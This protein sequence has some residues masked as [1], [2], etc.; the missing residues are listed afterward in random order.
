MTPTDPRIDAYIA[1]SA[2]FAKPIL[3][4]LR[5]VV[6]SSC[7]DAQETIKWGMPHFMY[8]DRILAQMAAFKAHCAFSF[9]RNLSGTDKAAE[10]MGQFGRITT[11]DDL[12]A[13]AEL[14][15]L[16]KQAAAQIDAGGPPPKPKSAP[17]PP[18]RAPE[19]LAAAL[20]RNAKARKVFEAF[21][22]GQQREYIDWVVEAKRAETREKRLAQA[23]EWMEEGKVRNWKYQDC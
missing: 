21:T 17:K 10:A 6:H 3:T 15:R 12:P 11:L 20:R 1:K 9:W 7:P 19:D 13:K 23:V 22:P 16:V 8:G 2:D 4:H 18:P 5:Q 14:G